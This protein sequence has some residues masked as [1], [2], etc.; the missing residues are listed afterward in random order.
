MQEA[1][2][3]HCCSAALFQSVACSQAEVRS[4]EGAIKSESIEVWAR[5]AESDEEICVP[6]LAPF[7]GS[8]VVRGI[9]G[10]KHASESQVIVQWD[11][12]PAYQMLRRD[13]L[14][15]RLAHLCKKSAS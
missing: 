2:F 7:R 1:N 6:V 9:Q 4:V 12:H 8:Q 14:S 5:V 11:Q 13:R 3:E 15:R 10:W